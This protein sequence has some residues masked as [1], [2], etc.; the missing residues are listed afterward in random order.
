MLKL[1][2][3]QNF[4]IA[5]HLEIAF[6][7]G[8]NILTGETGAGKSILINAIS[9]VVGGRISTE[10]V[11]TGSSRAIVSGVFDVS[12]L[13]HVQQL[14]DELGIPVEDEVF[15]RREI[16]VK[17]TSRAFIN[18]VPVPVNTLTRLGRW[19]VDIH[20]QHE[21]QSLLRRETHR[22][23][24]DAFGQHESLLEA[25]ARTYQNM[26][27]LH[28]ELIQRQQQQRDLQEKQDLY[29]FQLEEIQKAALQPG[30]DEALEAERKLLANTEKIF[31]L[32]GRLLQIFNGDTV[33]LLELMG[34]AESHLYALGEFSEEI[35]KLAEEFATARV[36]SQEAARSI[37]E[38]QASLEFDPLRLEV[39]ENRLNLIRQLKKKYG[40]TIE[41]IL[42]YQET[43]QKQLQSSQN[44]EQEVAQLQ[45]QYQQAVA[46]YV[47][48]A[49]QL[50]QARQQVAKHLQEQV[51]QELRYLGMGGTRFAARVDRREEN[52]GD[53]QIDGKP[54]QADETGIDA[55]EFFIS[56]NPGEAFKPLQ[57]IASGGEISR[58]MLA[59]K[60]ILAR[61]DRVPT[62]I[63]D[64]IDV[65]VSGRIAGAVGRSIA[66]LAESHQVLCITHLPQ[67][68]SQKATHFV[69]E[70]YVEDGR[71]F[72]RVRHLKTPQ[73]VEEIARLL[74]G[75]RVTDTARQ[76]ARALMEEAEKSQ[77]YN[78]Q[79]H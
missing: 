75:E 7:P 13:P 77:T 71:T 4:A 60:R 38:F 70:K 79:N 52:N 54:V 31:E 48:H 40:D 46:S 16:P 58:I 9:A 6:T 3:V 35:R 24:L 1:L 47:K 14:L 53:I 67:I 33:S 74:S 45:Q 56:P 51:Q 18:N 55:V 61:I 11:R 72:V 42:Q 36:I 43:I 62:L 76:S 22:E 63:F 20:G 34:T 27:T 32:T 59:L 66:Q 19:L 41:A 44:F 2:T 64:E 23:L 65:G 10:V 28:D 17:G 21:H 5:E 29:R 8:L 57:K 12:S 49:L 37:E 50:S 26:Q 15:I 69:V 73:R 39:V 68:A 78:P 25:V 30:E